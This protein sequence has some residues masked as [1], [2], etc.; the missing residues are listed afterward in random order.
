MSNLTIIGFYFEFIAAVFLLKNRQAED[1]LKLPFF[2]DPAV[3][4][5]VSLC[6]VVCIACR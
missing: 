4:G 5:E 3:S 6:P 2:K 1:V